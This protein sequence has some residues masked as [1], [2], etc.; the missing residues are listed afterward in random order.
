[1]ENSDDESEG[2]HVII[3]NGS[4][5]MRCGLNGEEGPRVKIRS[6]VGYPKKYSSSRSDN[7]AFYIGDEIKSKEIPLNINYPINHG[8]IENWDDMEKIWG[9]LFTEGLKSAPCEHILF[10]IDSNNSKEYKE[11][12]AEVIFEN[13]QVKG[14]Y[15]SDAGSCQSASFGKENSIAV[16]LGGGLITFNPILDCR[17]IKECSIKYHF[18][19]NELT[20]FLF[21]L[22]NKIL[23]Y[24]L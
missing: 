22:H 10:L 13:L 12:M 21:L 24:K 14:L 1:M 23:P 4:S 8:I 9:Y 19:G 15:I 18:G 2:T 11:K 6:C 20:E 16:D 17:P 5:Y 7:K 3:D